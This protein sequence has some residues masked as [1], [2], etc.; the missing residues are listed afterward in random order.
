V[1]P[2]RTRKPE[3]ARRHRHFQGDFEQVAKLHND[4]EELRGRGGMIILNPKDPSSSPTVTTRNSP[5]PSATCKKKEVSQVFGTRQTSWAV[6]Q[7]VDRAKRAS[8]A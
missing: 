8:A 7:L 6:A 1:I 2:T 3:A 4:D 5:T